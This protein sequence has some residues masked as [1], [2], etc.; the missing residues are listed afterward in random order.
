MVTKQ[1]P[2]WQPYRVCSF[3]WKHWTWLM[4]TTLKMWLVSIF[5]TKNN[6][7]SVINY[8]YNWH[9]N[10]INFGSQC[11]HMLYSVLRFLADEAYT[12]LPVDS[13]NDERGTHS[14]RVWN[15]YKELLVHWLHTLLLSNFKGPYTIFCKYWFVLFGILF[16]TFIIQL[17]HTIPSINKK[18]CNTSTFYK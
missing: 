12:C 18:A 13:I 11:S 3:N 8:K 1:L 6:M 9:H 2:G 7:M 15:A 17:K 4:I 10:L 5:L 14:L 16:I